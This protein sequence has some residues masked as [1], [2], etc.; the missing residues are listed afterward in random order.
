MTRQCVGLTGWMTQV[1]NTHIVVGVQQANK[2]L[3]LKKKKA[4]KHMQAP[5]WTGRLITCKGKA[6][7]VEQQA[8]E[9]PV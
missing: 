8:Q 6:V 7:S 3:T 2:D 4:R 1:I 9:P 5:D